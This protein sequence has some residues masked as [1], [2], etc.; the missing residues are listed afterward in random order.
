[1]NILAN[2]KGPG[3]G[4]GGVKGADTPPTL[5]KFSISPVAWRCM[6]R[7]ELKIAHALTWR[8]HHWG[9]WGTFPT[10]ILNS[11]IYWGIS[12]VKSQFRPDVDP[13]SLKFNVGFFFN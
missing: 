13:L 8:I 9:N 6:E 12:P 7:T 4:G 11:D 2:V 1:M 10:G 5:G 3:K